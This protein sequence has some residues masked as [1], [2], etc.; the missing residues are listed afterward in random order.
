MAVE[1]TFYFDTT[2]HFIRWENKHIATPGTYAPEE[3]RKG[4]E[5]GLGLDVQKGTID[6]YPRP[7]VGAKRGRG[8][9]LDVEIGVAVGTF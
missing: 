8:A 3:F 2:Y 7:T 9:F 1:T 4:L 5:D 6:E